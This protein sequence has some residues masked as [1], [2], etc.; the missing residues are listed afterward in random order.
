MTTLSESESALID[1]VFNLTHAGP[2]AKSQARK[3]CLW[4]IG[5]TL[6]A[7]V[8]L[9]KP[10]EL[11]REMLLNGLWRELRAAVADIPEIKRTGE[12]KMTE[13]RKLITTKLNS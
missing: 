13:T 11:E 9:S 7:D 1:A 3:D 2:D 8:L 6:L 4:T 5:V 10:D 12:A